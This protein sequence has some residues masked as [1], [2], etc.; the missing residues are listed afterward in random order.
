MPIDATDVV[1]VPANQA[2]S[3]SKWTITRLMINFINGKRIAHARL[4]RCNVD[5][6]GKITEMAPLQYSVG[7][8]ILDLDAEA[9]LHPE[10]AAAVVA[11]NTAVDKLGKL[12]GKL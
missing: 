2:V 8:D 5:G 10:V 12:Q 11:V 3:Y 7:V 4:T 1:D 9:V 6:Q